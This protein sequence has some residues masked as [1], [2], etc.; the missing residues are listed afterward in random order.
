MPPVP[1]ACGTGT[2]F[3]DKVDGKFTRELQAPA[4]VCKLFSCLSPGPSA[5]S[6][7]KLAQVEALPLTV[8]AHLEPPVFCMPKMQTLW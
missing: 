8:F 4:P 7:A 3:I 5:D 6:R 1:P 2:H